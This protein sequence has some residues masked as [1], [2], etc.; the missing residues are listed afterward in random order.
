MLAFSLQDRYA[1][2]RDTQQALPPLDYPNDEAT[3]KRW[4]DQWLEALKDYL[5]PAWGYELSLVLCD[6]TEIAAL[7]ATYRGEPHP[8]DVLSF[9]A[10]L[11]TD[12]PQPPDKGFREE[13]VYLGDV[14][15]SVETAARQAQKSQQNLTT[16]V[17]W[18]ATH[19]LLHLLGWEHPGRDRLYEMLVWQTRLLQIS[20][21]LPASIEGVLGQNELSEYT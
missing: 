21:I 5:P 18:L 1:R 14:I 4:F 10:A 20:H 6:D 19:G 3:W 9:A 7:N 13:P 15:I 2:P 16:E 11:E 12:F 8:T 17:T